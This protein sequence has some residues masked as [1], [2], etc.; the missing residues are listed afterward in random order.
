MLLLLQMPYG[1]TFIF[2]FFYGTEQQKHDKL[3]SSLKTEVQ[4]PKG[5]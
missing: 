4:S 5:F 3:H 2:N 1:F